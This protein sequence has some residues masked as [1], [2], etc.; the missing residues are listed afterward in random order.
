[1]GIVSCVALGLDFLTLFVLVVF[2]IV[3]T[4]FH[5]FLFEDPF[6]LLGEL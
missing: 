3:L 4:I 5:M 2:H 1:L 6:E